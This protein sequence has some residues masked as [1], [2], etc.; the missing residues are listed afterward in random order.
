VTPGRQRAASA[1]WYAF[2][3]LYCAFV[4]GWLLL[5]LAAALTKHLSAMHAWAEAAEAGRHGAA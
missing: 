1:A 4:L 2:T 3:A 5:G